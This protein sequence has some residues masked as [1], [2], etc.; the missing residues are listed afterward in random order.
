MANK[1]QIRRG[2]KAS[3]PSLSVGEPALCT[4]TKELFVGNTGGN[5]GLVS[6]EAFDAHLAEIT[7][8]LNDI[9]ITRGYASP[10]GLK[11][12]VVESANELLNT[13][14]YKVVSSNTLDLPITVGIATYLIEVFKASGTVVTQRATVAYSTL[15]D[16]EGDSFYRVKSAAIG[17][18]PWT[19]VATAKQKNWISATL[20][21]GW[22]GTLK[23]SKNDLGQ[24]VLYGNLTVGTI[25]TYTVV[26]TLPSEYRPL[27]YATC[28]VYMLTGANTGKVLP[29]LI[30]NRDTDG[31]RVAALNGLATGDTLS[32]VLIYQS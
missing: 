11:E 24:V 4:D 13:G 18:K 10:L 16:E 2:L 22:T 12:T 26:T 19:K 3:L 6:K 15:N 17:W 30:Y 27:A 1:I 25:A 20:Q 7:T 29:A 8:D 31:L 14:F 23:Y 9:K 21:N 28:N 5:I 32:F